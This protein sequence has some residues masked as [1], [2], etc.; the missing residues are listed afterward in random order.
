MMPTTNEDGSR[1]NE[2]NGRAIQLHPVTGGGSDNTQTTL[3]LHTQQHDQSTPDPVSNPKFHNVS[4]QDGGTSDSVSNPNIQD[5]TNQHDCGLGSC[6][7]RALQC[8]SNVLAFALF[9]GFSALVTQSMNMYVTSQVTTLE[10]QFHLSSSESGLIISSN[11]V[12]F[13]VT[14]LLAS[15]FGHR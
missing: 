7:P 14:V 1:L 8:C 5:V 10:K 11:E 15:H 12:G 9:V 4:K 6:K 13:L 3:P 2:E